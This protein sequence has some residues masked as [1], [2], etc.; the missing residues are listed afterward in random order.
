LVKG[1]Q[2][3]PAKIYKDFIAGHFKPHYDSIFSKDV[4][5]MDQ[6]FAKLHSL[7]MLVAGQYKLDY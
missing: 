7:V 3:A 1:Q 6:L 4:Y 5:S 2:V